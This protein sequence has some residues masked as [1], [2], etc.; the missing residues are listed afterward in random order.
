M[1]DAIFAYIINI[2]EKGDQG[3]LK[4]LLLEHPIYNNFA[5]NVLAFYGQQEMFLYV[6]ESSSGADL[7]YSPEGRGNALHA[8]IGGGHD[9][10]ARL[11]LA[12]DPEIINELNAYGYTALYQAVLYGQLD[13]VELLLAN[14]ADIKG[15]DDNHSPLALAR[16]QGG[17]MQERLEIAN[18][19]LLHGIEPIPDIF[20]P[21]QGGE[22]L[23]VTNL[24]GFNIDMI[25]GL[26]ITEMEGMTFLLGALFIW[27]ASQ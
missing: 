5:L 4:A 14:G 1:L 17:E 9:N 7:R 27:P 13:M 22:R 8:A 23:T 24:L 25:Q 18:L 19:L 2:S 12:R 3:A 20:A 16:A 15:M 11:I 10:M 21:Y 6:L 26:E